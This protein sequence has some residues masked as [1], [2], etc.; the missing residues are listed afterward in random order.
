VHAARFSSRELDDV[1]A[2]YAR[3]EL[4]PTP[5]HRLPA[6]AHALGIGELLVKD[7]TARF[8]LSSFKILGAHYAIGR[9]AAR[10]GAAVSAIACATAGNHG[11]AVTSA[12]RNLGLDVHV[13]VPVG[14]SPARVA[15]LRAA[16]AQVVV[17]RVAYDATVRLMAAEARRRGWRVVSDTALGDDDPDA[18]PRAIMAGYTRLLDEA[19]AQWLDAPDIVSVQAG[20][21][22][23][24]GAVAGWLQAR[25]ADPRRRPRLVIA[26]PAGSACVLASLRAGRLVT[27]RRCA[28]TIMTGLRCGRVSPLAWPVLKAGVSA[29]V[30]V[31]DAR[32]VEAM[33]RLGEPAAAD[34]IVAAG[35]SGACGLAALMA[36]AQEA[37]LRPVRDHLGLNR[38]ASVFVIATEALAP[39]GSAPIAA[40]QPGW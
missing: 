23:L 39:P 35:P 37:G 29:A 28:P 32:S 3:H 34:P 16:G 4:P 1:R 9:L 31:S 26:E 11:L 10:P 13:F 30:A 22:S 27:L 21:G 5:L 6:L 40:L 33:R 20:V 19:A 12:G 7:E 15:A 17:T 24:A 38:A 36:I 14:T 8:G 18:I 2:W 25:F